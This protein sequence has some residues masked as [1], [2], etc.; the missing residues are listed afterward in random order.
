MGSISAE[1]Y[2]LMMEP[3]MIYCCYKSAFSDIAEFKGIYIPDELS[4]KKRT[5]FHESFNC[6]KTEPV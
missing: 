2:A 3:Q 1:E 4:I 5:A 6:Y